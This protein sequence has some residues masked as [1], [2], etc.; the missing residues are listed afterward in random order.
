MPGELGVLQKRRSQLIF[1]VRNE[2]PKYFMPKLSPAP[3]ASP[4]ILLG[5]AIGDL[6][7]QQAGGEDDEGEY[8]LERREQHLSKLGEDAHQ[9][10]FEILEIEQAVKLTHHFAWLHSDRDLCDFALL[11]E[12]ESSAI[13]KRERSVVSKFPYHK[14][15]FWYMEFR[16]RSKGVAD[17]IV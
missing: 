3:R 15:S 14:S 8:D 5:A 16:R 11:R 2:L 9:Y 6:P 7:V 4:R 10:L 13:A 12:G 17:R 1:G